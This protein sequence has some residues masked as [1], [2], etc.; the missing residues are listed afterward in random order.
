MQSLQSSHPRTKNRGSPAMAN[1]SVIFPQVIIALK[2]KILNPKF[3]N[4]N[5]AITFSTK[6]SYFYMAAN[7]NWTIPEINFSQSDTETMLGIELSSTSDIELKDI[8]ARIGETRGNSR[9]A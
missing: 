1:F 8:E 4:K 2:F 3:N 9:L 7:K 5:I 6:Y